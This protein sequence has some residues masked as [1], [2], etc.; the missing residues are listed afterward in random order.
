MVD[1]PELVS[2]L[3]LDFVRRHEP[4]AAPTSTRQAESVGRA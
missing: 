2:E 4:P 1:D 3:I